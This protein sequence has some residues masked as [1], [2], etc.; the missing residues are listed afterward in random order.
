MILKYW[1]KMV[2][3]CVVMAGFCGMLP[4]GN[5]QAKLVANTNQLYKLSLLSAREE[6]YGYG[7]K[8]SVVGGDVNSLKSVLSDDNSGEIFITSETGSVELNDKKCRAVIE[9]NGLSKF[10]DENWSID[11]PEKAGYV[12][13][14]SAS[15]DNG[16]TTTYISYDI[17]P[18]SETITFNQ[19]EKAKFEGKI[20]YNA[21][22]GTCSGKIDAVYA[23]LNAVMGS[24]MCDDSSGV[25]Q[26]TTPGGG[27]YFG[28]DDLLDD[29]GQE[30]L[31]IMQ[32][33]QTTYEYALAENATPFENYNEEIV[34]SIEPNET[35]VEEEAA[36]ATYKPS[37]STPLLTAYASTKALGVTGDSQPGCVGGTGTSQAVACNFGSTAIKYALYYQY[38]QNSGY[39]S[40]VCDANVENAEYKVK[41]TKDQWC[42]IS[43]GGATLNKYSVAIVG[44]TLNNRLV[45]G[46]MEDVAKWLSDESSYSGMEESEYADAE[47]NDDGIATLETDSTSGDDD[48]ASDPC[49]ASG[50]ALGWIICPIVSGLTKLAENVY[51]WIEANFLQVDIAIFDND[52]GVEEAWTNVLSIANI[53]FIILLLIVIFSQLT[54]VGIDNYG[55]KRTLPKLILCAILV[56][57]SY[58]ICKVCVDVSNVVGSGIS[59]LLSDMGPDVS[60]VASTATTGQN[61]AIGGVAVVGI[62][63]TILIEGGLGTLLLLLMA[64][65]SCAIAALTLFVTL[66]VRQ[67]GIIICIVL[68]P[69]AIVC[70]TLPNTEKLFKKWLDFFK[71]LLLAYPICGLVV[72]GGNAVARILGNASSA[73]EGGVKIGLAIGAMLV[74]VIP[75]FF[76]PKLISSSLGALSA[77]GNAV[78]KFGGGLK[79]RI[80]KSDTYNNMR[81]RSRAGMTRDGE[82]Y[83]KLGNL[84]GKIAKKTG[85]GKNSVARS[86]LGYQAHIAKQGSL[87]AAYGEDLMLETL[88]E[89][90][91]KRIKSSGEINSQSALERGLLSALKSN[92]RAQIRAYTDALSARGEDGR[93]AV[94]KQWNAAV[95]AGIDSGAAKTFSDNIMANHAADYKNNHRSLFEVA[96]NI[97]TGGPMSTTTGFLDAGGRSELAKKVTS[98]TIGN[99]D[100]DAF[101]EIFVDGA[102]PTELFSDTEVKKALGEV[103]YNAMHDQ[104]ANIKPERL[105]KIKAIYDASGYQPPKTNVGTVDEVLRVHHDGGA[106]TPSGAGTPPTPPPAPPSI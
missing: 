36:A 22:D 32:S 62:A 88:T 44:G 50:E 86:R 48:S 56:N 94:K 79:G 5:A 60:G 96:K 39:T 34:L 97:N 78:S 2:L 64:L 30:L 75:Y 13:D 87:D 85:I 73:E 71:K 76:I 89:N 45:K 68:A 16:Y 55:I 17:V 28:S 20:S 54:G 72:G 26:I 92:N 12:L 57:L 81:L 61:I 38:I 74:Q 58:L 6:C 66:V 7:I 51:G 10:F 80:Q 90:E 18:P 82:S 63:A 42:Q 29:L 24:L 104:N 3:L 98:T 93:A 83:T 35:N 21:A 40:I 105:A 84:R 11:T 23:N 102:I 4:Q 19:T 99:M 27:Y 106:S 49:Y 31:W 1:K 46:T 77:I 43:T 103:C 15:T 53:A 91:M 14:N 100:K 67:A 65:L 101:D 95:T 41:N 70:Y 69:V 9:K 52:S 33:Y 8:T 59:G 47:V 25:S 37:G